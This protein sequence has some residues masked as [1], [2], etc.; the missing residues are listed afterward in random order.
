MSFEKQLGCTAMRAVTPGVPLQGKWL[1]ALQALG[2]EPLE[3]L[4]P[5]KRGDVEF[6]LM[7]HFLRCGAMG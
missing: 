2:W 1:A 5:K 6:S 7:E 4:L 3:V